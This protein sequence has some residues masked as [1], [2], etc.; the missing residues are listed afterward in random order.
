MAA[1]AKISGT[2]ITCGDDYGFSAIGAKN[3]D[4]LVFVVI[5][6]IN[7]HFKGTTFHKSFVYKASISHGAAVCK[8]QIHH[9]SVASDSVLLVV[10]LKVGVVYLIGNFRDFCIVGTYVF[11]LCRH[12]R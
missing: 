4:A 1:G 5:L 11:V 9:F 2:V 12:I 8:K 10:E 3:F 6:E 7:R